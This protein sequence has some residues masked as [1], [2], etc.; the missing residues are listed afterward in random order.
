MTFSSYRTF[1]TL[2]SK[3][4]LRRQSRVFPRP[5][6]HRCWRI[7][8]GTCSIYARSS[9]SVCMLVHQARLR[10]LT[11]CPGWTIRGSGAPG[12]IFQGCRRHRV[13]RRRRHGFPELYTSPR[14]KSRTHVGSGLS[15][16]ERK[17]PRKHLRGE[18]G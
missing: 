15:G 9:E 8:S 1:V 13:D 18:D 2:Y 5:G 11:H 6:K 12:Q 17:E 3:K 7:F 4:H 14:L 16:G 10:N